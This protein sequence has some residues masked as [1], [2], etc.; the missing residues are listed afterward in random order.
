V[1]FAV[2]KLITISFWLVVY[3]AAKRCAADIFVASSALQFAI[4]VIAVIVF[5]GLSA[6]DTQRI[7]DVV[8]GGWFR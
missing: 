1:P 4:S 5:T 2:T 6:W 3:G 8:S 7:K